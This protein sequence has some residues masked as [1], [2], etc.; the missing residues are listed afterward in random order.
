M[1]PSQFG[2]VYSCPY[3]RGPPVLG[4][5]YPSSHLSS[6]GVITAPSALWLLALTPFLTPVLGPTSTWRCS[7]TVS[8]TVSHLVP[9]AN[10]GPS[11]TQSERGGD[12]LTCYTHTHTHTHTTKLGPDSWGTAGPVP[13]LAHS[14]LVVILVHTQCLPLSSLDPPAT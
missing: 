12:T 9:R 7:T 2:G 11:P 10:M 8:P 4:L 6:T 5:S 14:F 3:P 1:V 13:S